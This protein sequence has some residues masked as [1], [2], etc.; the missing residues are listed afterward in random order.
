MRRD[1]RRISAIAAR[2]LGTGR[3]R[4]VALWC[5]AHRAGDQH[6]MLRQEV[7]TAPQPEANTGRRPERASSGE[8]GAVGIERR[9]LQDAYA[10]ERH[11][12]GRR[13]A[14]RGNTCAAIA[15]QVGSVR[16]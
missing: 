10:L 3:P 14:T 13:A 5:A 9:V 16:P 7:E 12:G 2:S 6:Q 15:S 8:S 1:V 11:A 4:A